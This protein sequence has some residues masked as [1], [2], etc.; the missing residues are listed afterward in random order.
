LSKTIGKGFPRWK[1]PQASAQ[2][3]DFDMPDTEKDTDES[4]ESSA[5]GSKA[6]DPRKAIVAAAINASIGRPLRDAMRRAAPLAVVA[7]VPST[8]WIKPVAGFF[9]GAFG[10]R[11][12]IFARDGSQRLEHTPDV[13]CDLVASSLARGDSVIG[14]AVTPDRLLPATLTAA[15][16]FRI[17]ISVDARVLRRSL[18]DLAG[19]APRRLPAL[20]LA[21]L[22][23]N[24]VV[25]AMRPRSNPAE[26]LSR[27]V[28]VAEH[29]LGRNSVVDAPDLETAVEFGAA[30][31]FGLA[32]AKDL[33]E[34]MADRQ[35]GKW[36][37][38][39]RGAIFF[40]PPGL[41]KSLLARSIA[42]H[43]RIPLTVGSIGELFASSAGFLDS[44]VKAQ[45]ALFASAAASAEAAGAAL[46]FLDE[47][48]ALP[49]R[50]SFDSK[51]GDSRGASWWMPVITD[52]L[53]LLDDATGIR[54]D[55][56][57]GRRGRVIVIGAT[58]RIHAVD[59]A[60]LRPG[61]LERA[62]EILPPDAAGIL[63]ILRFHAPELR[64]QQLE[65]VAHQLGGY[66]P[67]EIMDTVRAA[68]RAARQSGRPLRAEDIA[69]AALPPMALSAEALFR[70]AVH[71]AGHAVVAYALPF[72]RVNHIRIGGR[73]TATAHTSIEFEE[74]SFLT[75]DA[76]AKRVTIL[77]GGRAA[78]IEL[79][80]AASTGAQADLERASSMLSALHFSYGLG[81]ELVHLSDAEHAHQEMRRNPAIRRQVD[82]LLKQLQMRAIEIVRANRQAVAALAETVIEQRFVGGDD[83]RALLNRSEKSVVA[84]S[85]RLR[86]GTAS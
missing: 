34:Y 30:R 13:G 40:S 8:S 27:L 76:I 23:L 68:R 70:V 19:A 63:N 21:A 84:G 56:S 33:R 73:A 37:A 85:S 14:I 44:V 49:S 54:P 58:N 43:C 47:I 31:E 66:T 32:L 74:G 77:M 11:W 65:R 69:T 61:R 15:A 81:H 64:A 60:I 72:G 17:N 52:F 10:R 86:P 3:T 2:P 18:R 38:I 75:K 45:R 5:S 42:Q 53:L 22:D 1:P 25:A 39:D 36:N 16:D 80:G 83:I 35:P 55:S 20:N 78:E 50:E 48:D 24:D 79:L 29:R 71:E 12:T 57:G 6:N 51:G 46:L 67:A 62:I 82:G 7:T 4:A 59:P 28:Q 9:E 41:G 26:V